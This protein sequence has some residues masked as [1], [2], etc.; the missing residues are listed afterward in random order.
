[1][2]KIKRYSRKNGY[3]VGNVASNEPGSVVIDLGQPK[4]RGEG[5][6]QKLLMRVRDF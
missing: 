3:L 6:E 2:R 1:M 5:G 4:K